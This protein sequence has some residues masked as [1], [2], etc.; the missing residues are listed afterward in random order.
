MALLHQR[1]HQQIELLIQQQSQSA[2]AASTRERRRETLK[3]EVSKYRGVKEDPLLRWFLEMGDAIKARHI[4]GEEM[5]VAFA[6]SNLSGLARTCALNLQLHNPNVFG[7]LAVFK[8]LLSQTFEPPR[9]EFRT[10]S[11]LLTIKQGKRDVYAYAQHVRYLASCMVANPVSEFVLITIFL[12]GLIDGPV[13]NHSFCI[14]LKSLE[15]AITT[16]VQE[17]FSVRHAHTRLTPYL[18]SIR[19]EAGGPE[20]MNLCSVESERRRPSS[21][22]QLQKCNRCQKL[23]H[24]AYECSASRVMSRNTE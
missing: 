17:S 3:L 22:K 9:A 14:E 8:T 7:S 16:T 24:Y 4:N 1:G 20:P 21:S 12:Q 19:V 10:L 5:Q 13:R 18:P 2:T 6:K 23:G 11:E 15:E